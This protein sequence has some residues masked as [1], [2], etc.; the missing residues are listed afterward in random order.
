MDILCY[1]CRHL[2]LTTKDL[3]GCGVTELWS[4]KKDYFDEAEEDDLPESCP[5]FDPSEEEVD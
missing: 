4:C 2:A 5:D 3:F 1:D